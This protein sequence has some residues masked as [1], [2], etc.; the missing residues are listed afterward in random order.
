MPKEHRHADGEAHVAV[1]EVREKVRGRAAGST[2][3][4]DHGQGRAIRDV[5]YFGEHQRKQRHDT[6]LAQKPTTDATDNKKEM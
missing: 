5:E 4:H 3:D 2:A 1:A 6:E